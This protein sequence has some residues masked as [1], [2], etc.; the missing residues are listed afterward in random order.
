MNA[1]HADSGS[2]RPVEVLC[3]A[4]Q[5]EDEARALLAPEHGP[6]EFIEH[7][8]EQEQYA[9]AVQLLA[10]ALPTREAI[11]WA[12]VCAR[13]AAGAE[14]AP[15][16]REG[17]DAI[18]RW[19][20]QPANATRRPLF[21]LAEEIGVD[22]PVG[23]AALAVFFSGGSLAPPEAPHV[24]PIPYAAA[25]AIFGSVMLSAGADEPEPEMM[26]ERFRGYIKQ[27]VDV[28]QRINLWPPTAA[29]RAH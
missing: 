11:W 29:P 15:E 3:A 2:A 7:L 20:T 19:I 18:E 13:R 10:H 12:W 9:A 8:V 22:T 4:A 6:R 25:K 14:P 5:L 27:G 17:L 16:V 28:A 21:S 26:A 24:E 1:P 23:A